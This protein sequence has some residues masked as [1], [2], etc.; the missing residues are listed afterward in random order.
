MSERATILVICTGNFCRS[1]MAVAILENLLQQDRRDPVIHALSAGTWTR[2][3]I[4][5]SPLAMEVMEERGLDI[6]AHRSHHLSRQDV[7]QAALIVT[8]TRDHKEALLAEFPAAGKKTFLLSELAGENHD[9]A[10]PYGSDS[11]TEYRLCASEISRLLRKSYPRLLELAT[12]NKAG[13]SDLK[14]SEDARDAS[15][16]PS[17]SRPSAR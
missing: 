2:D 9:V 13:D 6:S 11:L 3:G 12:T 1:P 5:A 15:T 10:D 14:S 16:S 8:M 17:R 4:A 7:E